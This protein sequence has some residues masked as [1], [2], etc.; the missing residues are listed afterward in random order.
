[1]AA[2]TKRLLDAASSLYTRARAGIARLPLTCRPGIAAASAFY[3]AIGTAIAAAGY[4]S[5][6]ARAYVPSREKAA[7][8]LRAVAAAYLPGAD[9]TAPALPATAYLVAAAAQDKIPRIVWVLNLFER[10]ERDQRL[11]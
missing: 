10:L 4:D 6:T 3:H 11:A 9:A 2:V 8:A 7:L 5:V 1:L